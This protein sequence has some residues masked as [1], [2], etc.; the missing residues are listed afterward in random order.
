MKTYRTTTGPF[1]ERPYYRD[2]EIE[3]MCAE[4]LRVAGLYPATPVPVRIDRFIEKHFGVTPRYEELAENILGFT[5][6][7]A[8]GVQDVVVARGLEEEGSKTADRRIRTTLAHEAG[9]G[10]LHT[11]LFLLGKGSRPLFADF[12]NQDSPRVLCK[13]VPVATG[14]KK[15]G[16]DGRW[17]EF[18]ANWTIGPLL[19]PGPLARYALEPLLEARG[20]FGGMAL[21]PRRREEAV[22]LLSDV[23]DVNPVVARIRLQDLYPEGEERQMS[24]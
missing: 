16:Y 14:F 15:P 8:K 18:Q 12:T 4:A 17:W 24:L 19:L 10:L 23:F 11:H 5:V 13:D 20:T 6:F 9:H 21:D 2:E 7:G 1:A 22:Q 3:T